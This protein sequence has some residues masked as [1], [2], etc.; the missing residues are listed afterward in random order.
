MSASAFSI[1]EGDRVVKWN[2]FEASIFASASLNKLE[3]YQISNRE[4]KEGRN[5]FSSLFSPVKDIPTLSCIEWSQV[6]SRSR[7]LLFGT[8][9]GVVKLLDSNTNSEVYIYLNRRN[10]HII[11]R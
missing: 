1:H 11:A 4:L 9:N 8:S 2:P 7:F 5:R 10:Y 3:I 6:P